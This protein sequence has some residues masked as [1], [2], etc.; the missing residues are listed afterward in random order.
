L[1]SDIKIPIGL[2]EITYGDTVLKRFADKAQFQA[3]PTYKKM[4]KG[5][6]DRAYLLEAY[7]VSL[8]LSLT[9]ETYQNLLLAIPHLQQYQ[10]GYY[11][12]PSKV[13]TMGKTLIIHPLQA[14]NSKEYDIVIFRA[15]PDPEQ[16]FTR[17]YDKKQDSIS[18]KFIGLPG[19]QINGEKF[20]SYFFIG[21][22]QTSGVI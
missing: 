22:W 6:E 20:K 10:E 15:I 4:Y 11:D 5:F 3:I 18:V 21:D 2:C 9:E 13:D 1:I 19:K 8:T 14:G 12:N 17:T 16:L 7:E